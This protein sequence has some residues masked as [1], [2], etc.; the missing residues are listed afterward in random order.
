MNKTLTLILLFA[1]AAGASA[2]QKP[3]AKK[4]E[5]KKPAPAAAP[6][7]PAA[8]PAQAKKDPAA[9][10]AA[11]AKAEDP[12]AEIVE[13]L[14]AWDARLETL[15]ADFTQEI[16]FKEA[17]LKQSIEGTLL[18]ARPNLLRI[19]HLKPSRQVVVTDKADIWIYK[20]EDKQVVRTDWNAW[21]RTQDQNFSGI[22]DFG[23]Y[24]ALVARNETRVEGGKDG[25]PVKVT[26]APRSGAAYSLTLTLSAADHF[27]IEAEL[28]V[29]GTVIKTRLSSAVKNG[30]IDKAVFKFSPPKG[31]ET[32][33]FRN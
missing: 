1:L 23:N 32:L 21:R 5:Q 25:A 22:L 9:Q 12:A 26:F 18:Y 13:K 28:S 31:T 27:P 17:G 16:H 6:A 4:K 30:E 24:S 8:A 2:Q 14:K 10:P 7:K 19:E 11:A 3:A 15:K 29:E 20:P 33:E